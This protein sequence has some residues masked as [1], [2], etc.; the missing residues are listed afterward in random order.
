[1]RR[2]LVGF[3]ATIGAL[4]I[5]A[6]LAAGGLG[7][8]AASRLLGPSSLPEKI[9]LRVDL[10][11]TIGEVEGP[12]RLGPAGLGSPPT[13]S[14]VV[15]ALDRARRDPRVRGLVGLVG[16]SAHGLAVARELRQAV[17]RFR[18]SGRFALAWSDSFA[19]LGSGIEGYYIASA[20]DE[21][22]LQPVGAVGLTGLLIEAPFIRPLLDRLGIDAAVSRRADYKTALESFTEP[23]PTPANKEMLESLADS[24]HGTLVAEIAAGRR[25]DPSRASGLVGGGPYDAEE[26]RALGL[27][28]RLAYRDEIERD[29]RDRAGDGAELVD[30]ERYERATAGEEAETVVALVRAAGPIVRGSGELAGTIAGDSLAQ[31]I[32]D[33][34]EASDV[35]AILLRLD[36]PGGSAV[37]SETV[38]REVRR[39]AAAGKPVVVSMG[40]RAASGGYWIAADAARIVAQPTTLTGSIGVLAGKPVLARAWER[41]GVN[42]ARIER[43]EHAALWS[44]NVPFDAAGQA[45]VERLLDSLYGTFKSGVARARSL[46]LEQVE[47]IARGRV[48]T[49]AQARELGLVDREGGLEEALD[50]IRA[51]L[52]L[53][54]D[55]P[56][57]L[58][59]V[60]EE[61]AFW[62]LA[63][64]LIATSEAALRAA[65]QLEALF[66]AFVNGA[67]VL[68][69]F[70]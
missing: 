28:D 24:L 13:L 41:L 68:P 63:S 27:V 54:A 1:M 51:V 60:P 2:F 53:P 19:E 70:R 39:A 33:A 67:V 12:P 5:L 7:W 66:E 48:W 40:N 6:L 42:W 43:G 52:A 20:F 56:L 61:R 65:T 22:V 44:I 38:A 4:T 45:R 31:T 11:E 64:R 10:R 36:S 30:L 29:A 50:E 58:R 34:I 57:R 15:L 25:L 35:R 49:G 69:T 47:D 16:D 32:A 23:Y 62:R 26:A 3:L 21:V 14:E 18:A 9:V 17:E 37:A 8:W 55:T 59:P 46:S